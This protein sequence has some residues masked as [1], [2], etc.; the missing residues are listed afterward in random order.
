VTSN[1]PK[2]S[3][4][5]FSASPGIHDALWMQL[6]VLPASMPQQVYTHQPSLRFGPHDNLSISSH[7][8]ICTDSSQLSAEFCG[9][10]TTADLPQLPRGSTAVPHNDS[11]VPSKF[12][13]ALLNG[14]IYEDLE[15]LSGA[16]APVPS[17]DMQTDPHAAHCDNTA[18]NTTTSVRH[19]APP[20]RLL[21][22]LAG[23]TGTCPVGDV[24]QKLTG[25]QVVEAIKAGKAYISRNTPINEQYAAST[26]NTG[27]DIETSS[28]KALENSMLVSEIPTYAIQVGGGWIINAPFP[29]DLVEPPFIRHKGGG[30]WCP[31]E[32][33]I[34][35][36]SEKGMRLKNFSLEGA[37]SPIYSQAAPGQADVRLIGSTPVTACELVTV[38]CRRDLD[39]MVR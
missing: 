17:H 23:L 33:L 14:T 36:A 38:S 8:S 10:R 13:N 28:K 19:I 4:E 6:E 12:G 39:F 1:L 35:A 15:Q 27:Y 30:R 24:L 7:L 18:P 29:A 26:A 37:F 5:S 2:L 31:P 9:Y 3:T 11:S 16:D 34:Y 20:R 21:H 25:S 22:A 32:G